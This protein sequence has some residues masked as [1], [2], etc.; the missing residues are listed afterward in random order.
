MHMIDLGHMWSTIVLR[1]ALSLD[2]LD[3]DAP[4]H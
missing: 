1:D 4:E 2:D 3:I